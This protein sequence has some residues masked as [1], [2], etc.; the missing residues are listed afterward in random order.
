M[1]LLAVAVLAALC[2]AAAADADDDVC[3]GTGVR[4]VLVVPGFSSSPLY[5]SSRGFLR[6]FPLLEGE[7]P[8][9]FG[10]LELPQQFEGLVQ[11]ETPVGPESGPND[12]LPELTG[13]AGDAIV[14]GVRFA[15]ATP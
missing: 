6:V 11:A 13:V 9:L 4:P 15:S 14:R 1:R 5:D 12:T 10:L 3:T 2:G 7:P 8:E